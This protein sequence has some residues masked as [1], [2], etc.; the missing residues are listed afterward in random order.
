MIDTMPTPYLYLA[1]HS[2]DWMP[3]VLQLAGIIAIYRFLKN[4]VL[5]LQGKAQILDVSPLRSRQAPLHWIKSLHTVPDIL[6]ILSSSS[7]TSLLPR[8]DAGNLVSRSRFLLVLYRSLDFLTYKIQPGPGRTRK[9][10]RAACGTAS[11]T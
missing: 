2:T 9:A 10:S 3:P 11:T 5:S 8:A 7:A 6:A 1:Q 4:I